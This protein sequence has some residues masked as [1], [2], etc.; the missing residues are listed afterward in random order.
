VVV[1]GAGAAGLATA[2]FCARAAPG[3]RVV[4]LDGAPRVGAK[5]LISGGSRCNVTNREV[6]EHDFWGGSSRIVRH[7][8]RAFPAARAAAFFEG[9][10]VALHEEEDGK[11]FPDTNRAR[12]VLDAL[13]AELVRVRAALHTGRRVAAVRREGGAFVVDTV[14][15]VRYVARTV[16]LATGG[17]SLPKTGSDGFGYELAKALGHG[18]VETTPALVP[19]VLGDGPHAGLSGV[20]H[21]AGL[22]IHTARARATRLEGAMLWT[23]FGISGPVALNASRHWHRAALGSPAVDVRLSLCPGET[24]EQVDAWLQEQE[25]LRPRTRVLTALATRLPTAVGDTWAT[26][27]GLDRD[28]TLAHL[29]REDRRRLV[30]GLLDTPLAIRGSRGYNYAEVTA[31]GVP[32][33]EVDAATMAS[34]VCPSLHLVGEMLD[35]D[36]RLGGF[37]FQWAWSSA[38]AAGQAIAKALAP[39]TPR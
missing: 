25:R 11:L 28:V 37:N 4:C 6:T 32:L 19:L 31:G 21:R 13:L 36:G 33:E 38:W 5:I 3:L 14:G 16:V 8:L 27:A 7:V 22:S 39:A 17:R 2:V 23:H 24:F 35:V 12:T 15:G 18:Y 10:G 34:R 20:T 1:V 29:T 30:R 26:R 9:L